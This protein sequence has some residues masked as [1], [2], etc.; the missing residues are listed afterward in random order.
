MGFLQCGMGAA[1]L[2]CI[3]MRSPLLLSFSH[4]LLTPPI[5]LFS[6]CATRL[7]HLYVQKCYIC[8]KELLLMWVNYIYRQS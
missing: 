2:V 3:E 8:N 1:M 6:G 7:A 5:Q 4:S